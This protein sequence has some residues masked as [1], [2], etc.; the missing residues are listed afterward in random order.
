M[1]EDPFVLTLLGSLIN[2]AGFYFQ[3]EDLREDE[4]EDVK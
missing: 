3:E 2:I 1:K 4:L